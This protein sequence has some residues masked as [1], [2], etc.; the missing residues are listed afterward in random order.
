MKFA[1]KIIWA[2]LL[3]LVIVF[4]LGETFILSQNHRH[5]LENTIQQNIL[6]YE[7]E[8]YNLQNHLLQSIYSTSLDNDYQEKVVNQVTYYLEQL[9]YLSQKQT[10]YALSQN[11]NILFSNM[12]NEYHSFISIKNNQKY[13]LQRYH[14][15]NLMFITTDIH[16]GEKQYYLTACYDI[17]YCYEERDRQFQS[18][19][20]TSLFMFVL[21]FFILRFVAQYMTKSIYK[22]N[23]VSQRIAEGEYDVRTHIQSEDEIGELSQN[24]DKMAEINE[25]TIQQLK[26]SV[27]QKEEFMGSFSHEIK[28]PMTA[29]F[30]F[31]DLLRTCDCDE[32]TR[33]KAAQY[34]YTEAKRL[35]SLSYAL[36]ELL[37]MGDNQAELKSISLQHV[38]SQLKE[39]YRGKT[40]EYI[41]IFDSIDIHVISHLDLLFILLRNLIDN[42]VKASE[43][44]QTIQVKAELQY[45]KL[46][47]SV[48]DEGIGMSQEDAKKATEAFYM[49]DKSRA[50]SQ[51][52]AGLGLAIV[53]RI[54][55]LHQ[56]QLLIESELNKG[57]TISFE[58]EVSN[59]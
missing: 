8:I 6:S 20:I 59:E 15:K 17:S 5:L 36:M 25:L 53:K 52:G 30:G 54:C 33:Q 38:F 28:T 3:T 41:I 51:G 29:I 49:A 34:I 24:F 57:T 4:S 35:E 31:A 56:T 10:S 47:I 11:N 19:F 55:H 27:I 26:E 42:A 12:N 43:K 9:H 14:H 23:K 46:R 50:R 48:I 40:N 32:E 2:C 39:Y 21:A 58:L 1:E 18:F 13:Y 16:L 45:S 44:G 7:L 22:L 37:S